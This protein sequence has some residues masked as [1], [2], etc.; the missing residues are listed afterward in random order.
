M[1]TYNF[2]VYIKKVIA[3]QTAKYLFAI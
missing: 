3:F 1:F 2:E